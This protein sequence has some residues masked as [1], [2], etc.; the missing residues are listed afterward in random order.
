MNGLS[1]LPFS[2]THGLRR[3]PPVATS[4]TTAEVSATVSVHKPSIL[5][6]VMA[7]FGVLLPVVSV[8]IP[9]FTD[10]TM[11]PARRCGIQERHVASQ[12]VS[13]YHTSRAWHA[14][15]ARGSL[16]CVNGHLTFDDRGELGSPLCRPC[17]R[18]AEL[19]V[20]IAADVSDRSEP[21]DGVLEGKHRHRLCDIYILLNLSHSIVSVVL[22]VIHLRDCC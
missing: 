4:T 16:G 15:V 7:A 12:P 3:T 19:M 1:H 18:R 2:F 11:R 20:V 5:D 8:F 6:P 13:T 10:L 21:D 14:A 17:E 22:Y 9:E